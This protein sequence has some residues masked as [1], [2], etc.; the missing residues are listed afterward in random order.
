[1]T[2]NYNYVI[3]NLGIDLLKSYFEVLQDNNL[4][5]ISVGSGNGSV[6]KELKP[7]ES[8]VCV[9][10]EP[11]S[12][13]ETNP[14]HPT[15][16]PQY[17]NIDNLLE[18]RKELTDNCNLFLNYPYP[19][20]K[21][22]YDIESIKKLKPKR[23]LT[24]LDTSGGAGSDLFLNYLDHCVPNMFEFKSFCD[25]LWVDTLDED[26][27]MLISKVPEYKIL[28]SS[29]ANVKC[30]FI[31]TCVRRY[32]LLVRTEDFPSDYFPK[33]EKFITKLVDPVTID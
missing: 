3:R 18:E 26:E 15:Q 23:I 1:M 14:S 27:E 4:T 8:I 30:S 11:F 28:E 9:D 22:R 7:D 10:P 6:E 17:D 31:G 2:Q 13:Q 19:N 29:T 25:F 5:C 21:G 12:F 32:M 16:N 24:V 20:M 33:Y